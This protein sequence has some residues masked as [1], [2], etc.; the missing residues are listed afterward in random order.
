MIL[1]AGTT[2]VDDPAACGRPEPHPRYATR[3]YS[4]IVPPAR[5]RLRRRYC[6]SSTRSG[7]G[8]IG[9]AAF[10]R[11]L[12]RRRQP[13]PTHPR[14]L[15][16]TSASS[17]ARHGRGQ[18]LEVVSASADRVTGH[19][20]QRHDHADHQDNDADRP[21]NRYSGDESDDEKNDA[22]N[23]QGRLLGMVVTRSPRGAGPF[24]VIA[25]GPG[26]G[27]PRIAQDAGRPWAASPAAWR[28]RSFR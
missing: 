19:P 20:E 9:A 27:A 26:L 13:D 15:T 16:C 11:A 6:S 10:R 4:L 17:A 18:R 25:P 7:S 1:P 23:D 14:V 22:E 8:F 21:E 5:A 28:A 2:P 24:R 3:R 12:N